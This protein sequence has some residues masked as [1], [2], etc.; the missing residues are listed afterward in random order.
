MIKSQ[1]SRIGQIQQI[2]HSLD[3][4]VIYL[5]IGKPPFQPKSVFLYVFNGRDTM[6][7]DALQ[8][9]IMLGHTLLIHTQPFHVLRIIRFKAFWILLVLRKGSC[10]QLFA[11][12]SEIFIAHI[13][14]GR[15]TLNAVVRPKNRFSQQRILISCPNIIVSCEGIL[16]PGVLPILLE[17][18]YLLPKLQIPFARLL[19]R[20]QFLLEFLYFFTTQ[21]IILL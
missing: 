2:P 11:H 9:F 7:E 10:C 14:K 17:L 8:H 21:L 6:M 12:D 13:L 20:L 4:V 1:I 18:F 15:Q 5:G 19:L 16:Y 3:H